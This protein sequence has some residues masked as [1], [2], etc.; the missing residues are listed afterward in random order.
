MNVAAIVLAAGASR[1]MGSPKPLLPW[2]DRT[3]LAWELDELRRSCVG[4]V[5][6]VT[7]AHADAVR[8]SLG[9]WG[10]CCVFHPR[11]AQGRATSLAAGASAFLGMARPRAPGSAADIAPGRPDVIVIQNV[12]QPT[13]ADIVDRL[14]EELRGSGAEAVQ[15][16]FGGERGHPVVLDG[17]LLEELAAASE[18]ELG[19]RSVLR[20]H[21]PR[22]LPM[23]GEPIVRL[24]LDTPAALAEGRRLC[25]VSA[26]AAGGSDGLGGGPAA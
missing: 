10:S 18:E 11:W 13:R 3:L 15:P 8:R 12:D 21:P 20:R 23:D 5:V 1:R 17:A 26:P 22:Q 4:D 2:G 16:S 24:D 6:V 7:G 9:E 25:G 19:L 14:V